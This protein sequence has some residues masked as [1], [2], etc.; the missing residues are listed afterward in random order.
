MEISPDGQKSYNP[1]SH[2][3]ETQLS[4]NHIFNC[5]S[6]AVD[7]LVVRASDSRPVG[8]GSMPDTISVPSTCVLGARAR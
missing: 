2:C 4:P 6:R 8:L 5:N 7:S 3:P 1:Y